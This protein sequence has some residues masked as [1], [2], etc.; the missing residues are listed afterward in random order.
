LIRIAIVGSGS[1]AALQK[2]FRIQTLGRKNN[3]KKTHTFNK[4]EISYDQLIKVMNEF[5]GEKTLFKIHHPQRGIMVAANE[6]I[7]TD[8]N[9]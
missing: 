9:R 7:L 4:D 1:L 8:K 5:S 2:M 6:I 3:C